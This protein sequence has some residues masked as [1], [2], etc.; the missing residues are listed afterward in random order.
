MN[1]SVKVVCLIPARE[2]SSRFPEKLLK[3][4]GDFSVITHTYRNA[5]KMKL[6]S[7]VFVVTNSRKIEKTILSDG[8][9]VVFDSNNY[10]C[11]SDRIA[12]ISSKINAD[13]IINIQGDEP[14][15]S[16]KSIS[17]IIEVFH[18]DLNRQIDIVSPMIAIASDKE[19]EDPNNVKVIT[20]LKRNAIYFSRSKIPYRQNLKSNLSYYK[21]QGVYGFRREALLKISKQ[22]PTP[23]E[24]HEQIEALRFLEMGLTIRMVE[25]DENSIAIDTREDLER[26]R[27]FY[28][29]KGGGGI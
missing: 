13:V 22:K 10:T 4:I 14:F 25:S 2:N 3:S 5:V 15:I 18:K 11:G 26:A 9:E 6:F 24:L 19:V 21:H 7:S 28:S 20:D 29:A 16:K 17:K 12:A 1:K 8:G 23:L 27:I